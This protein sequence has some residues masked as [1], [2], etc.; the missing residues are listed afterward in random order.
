MNISKLSLLFLLTMFSKTLHSQSQVLHPKT[1]SAIY[2]KSSRITDEIAFNRTSELFVNH[3]LDTLK[4]QFIADK[5]NING[6]VDTSKVANTIE[7]LKEILPQELF[8]TDISEKN[9]DDFENDKVRSYRID[10]QDKKEL[11]RYNISDGRVYNSFNSEEIIDYFT[12]EKVFFLKELPAERK[13]IKGYDCYKVIYRFHEQYSDS[14]IPTPDVKNER[15]LWVTDKIISPFHSIVRP[16]QI[17]SKYYPLEIIDK[18]IDV[19]GFET[20]Y[21]IESISFK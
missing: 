13:N 3:F 10:Q 2:I 8:R 5:Y 4:K 11:F 1:G 18:I 9:I 17:L 7:Q 12:A 16:K 19:N 20:S 6:D 15:V 21:V 14:E